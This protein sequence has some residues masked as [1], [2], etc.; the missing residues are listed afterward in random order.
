MEKNNKILA[1]TLLELLI[2]VTLISSIV[3]AA[4]LSQK[5]GLNF[6]KSTG[7]RVRLQNAA[8]IAIEEIVRKGREANSF[9]VSLVSG[10]GYEKIK[11]NYSAN[12]PSLPHEYEFGD[13]GT[14]LENFEGYFTSINSKEFGI[15]LHG[16]EGEGDEQKSIDLDTRV[17][18]RN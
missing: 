18:L 13:N 6:I 3:L 12:P 9:I 10:P 1:V 5:V 7:N 16:T 2:A 8:H 4:A 15:H 11:F 17:F 14:I